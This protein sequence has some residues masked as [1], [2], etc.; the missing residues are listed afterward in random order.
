MDS[1]VWIGTIAIATAIAVFFIVTNTKKYQK[2]VKD[3][4][5]WQGKMIRHFE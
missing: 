3:R 5:W 4:N 2:Y 1:T